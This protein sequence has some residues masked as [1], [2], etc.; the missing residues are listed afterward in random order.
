MLSIMTMFSIL[1]QNQNIGK[2]DIFLVQE[3]KKRK[4]Y[5]SKHVQGELKVGKVS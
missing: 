5:T 1:R 2:E 3:R 4:N